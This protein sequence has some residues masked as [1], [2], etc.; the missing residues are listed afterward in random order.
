MTC[1]NSGVPHSVK[2]SSKCRYKGLAKNT[3]QLQVLFAMA[4]LVLSQRTRCAQYRTVAPWG[5]EIR[6]DEPGRVALISGSLARIN[7]WHVARTEWVQVGTARCRKF[8][9]SNMGWIKN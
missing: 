2:R 4:N 6:G 3:V 5:P 8:N 7:Q 9:D 1:I